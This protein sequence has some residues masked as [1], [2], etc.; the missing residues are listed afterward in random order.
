MRELQHLTSQTRMA[1]ARDRSCRACSATCVRPAAATNKLASLAVVGGDILVEVDVLD[2]ARSTRLLHILRNAVDHGLE[3]P[4]RSRS[5]R[6]KPREGRIT[7]HS[8][9]VVGQVVTVQVAD[10]GRGL[11]ICRHPR[12]GES[13]RGPAAARRHAEPT[14]RSR[15]SR[16]CPAFSTRDAVTEISGRGVGLDVVAT[17]LRALSGA[18]DIRSEAGRAMTIELRFQASLVATHALFV[19]D[20]GQVFGSRATRCSRAV[21]AVRVQLTREDG[22]CSPDRR[23]V[24]RARTGDADRPRAGRPRPSAATSC[25][26]TANGRRSACSSTPCSTPANS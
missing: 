11:D 26:S 14:P 2:P 6:G 25:S 3:M 8:R 17:R 24:S 12:Q 1:P 10:D 23:I 9:R 16:C 4:R 15:A 22:A 20:G 7:L 5:G 21:P 13:S 18:I 19:R